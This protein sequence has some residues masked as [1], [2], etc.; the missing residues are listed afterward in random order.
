LGI[1]T[2]TAEAAI[3]SLKRKAHLLISDGEKQVGFFYEQQKQ[4]GEEILSLV[5]ILERELL[6]ERTHDKVKGHGKKRSSV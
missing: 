2:E 6:D 1:A 3:I 5:N 4:R